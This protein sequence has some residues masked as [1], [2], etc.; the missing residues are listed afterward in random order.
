MSQ[1][2][3][4][5]VIKRALY[6]EHHKE[7]VRGIEQKWTDLVTKVNVLSA[8]VVLLSKTVLEKLESTIARVNQ[9]EGAQNMLLQLMKK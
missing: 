4:I 8:N 6:L 7:L 5:E 3:Y 2:D 1:F 9:L